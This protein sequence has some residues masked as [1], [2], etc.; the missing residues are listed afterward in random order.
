MSMIIPA[1]INKLDWSPRGKVATTVKTAGADTNSTREVTEEV[2]ALAEAAKAFLGKK[3]GVECGACDG[4]GPCDTAKVED[5]KAPFG[6]EATD[7]AEVTDV[8]EVP[9]VPEAVEVSDKGD[10]EV[11]EEAEVTEETA[12]ESIEVAIETAEEAVA[13]AKEAVQELKGAE[14]TEVAEEGAVDDANDTTEVTE[15]E[16]EIPGV[17]ND[18]VVEDATDDKVVEDEVEKE[19]MYTTMSDKSAKEP[20]VAESSE[21]FCKFAKLSPQNRSKIARYWVDMLGYPKDYVSLL[22]KD[23]EK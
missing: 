21:E 2:D 1:G 13:E 6:E 23:Y 4:T 9:E 3:A 16:I 5:T 18:E 12:V 7:V 19:G 8:T 15:V 22:T 20:V 17:M 14:V 10:A 11:A